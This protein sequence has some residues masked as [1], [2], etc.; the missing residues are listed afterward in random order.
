M[1]IP[2]WLQ[3]TALKTLDAWSAVVPQA[4]P[5]AERLNSCK[6]VSHRGEHDN[7]TILENTHAAFQQADAAGVWGI[8]CDIRW[9]RDLHPVVIH[10]TD[11]RRLHGGDR[12]IAASRLDELLRDHPQI[13]TLESVVQDYGKRMHLMLEIKQERFPDP[14]QQRGILAEIL[15]ELSPVDDFHFLALEPQLFALVEGYPS[16]SFL[17]VAELNVKRLSQSATQLGLAGLAGHYYF[18]RQHIVQ[19]HQD[20]NQQIGSGFVASKNV[21]FRELNRGVE[22]VFSNHAVKLQG[23]VDELLRELD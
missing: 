12:V 2:V 8:E 14:R 3:N 11:C 13:P 22:W 4:P 7:R 18:L 16:P 5:T 15:H 10:D 19:R 20:N 1:E 21:L 23:I 9:T 6:I 17:P